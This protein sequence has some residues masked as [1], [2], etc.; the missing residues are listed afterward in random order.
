MSV[1]NSILFVPRLK[2]KGLVDQAGRTIVDI[3][4]VSDRKQSPRR[5]NA[6][7]DTG[8]T[9]E[10]VLPR[11]ISETIVTV[12]EENKSRNARKNASP[13]RATGTKDRPLCL[14][15]RSCFRSLDERHHSSSGGK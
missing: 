12:D 14:F 8:F 13:I 4:I 10:L 9:G 15:M 2:R 1:G 3:E 5:L 7:I 11:A 6:W